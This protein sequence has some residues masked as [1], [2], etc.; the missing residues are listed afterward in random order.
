MY[1]PGYYKTSNVTIKLPVIQA[2]THIALSSEVGAPG[3]GGCRRP[4]KKKKKKTT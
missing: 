2:S 1:L 3:E 4:K